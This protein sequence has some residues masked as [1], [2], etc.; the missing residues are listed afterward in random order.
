MKF[1][2]RHSNWNLVI[3]LAL[4]LLLVGCATDANDP[5]KI[6][7]IRLHLEVNPQMVRRNMVATVLR[8]HPEKITVAEEPLLHEGYVD[9]AD[10]VSEGDTFAIRLKFDD[11]GSRILANYTAINIGKRMAVLAQFPEIRWLAAPVITGRITNGVFTFTPDASLEECR[12][13]VDGLEVVIRHRKK[14]SVFK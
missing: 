8:A 6:S 11:Q 7:T 1:W 10:I 4:S 2:L 9:A 14:D 13:I 12:R 5:Q 3:A